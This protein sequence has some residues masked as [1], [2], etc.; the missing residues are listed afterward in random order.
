MPPFCV[1]CQRFM[2]CKK[3]G[4]FVLGGYKTYKAADRYACE[5]CESSVISGFSLEGLPFS[6]EQI[7]ASKKM[8][9]EFYAE[10]ECV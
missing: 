8:G 7:E 2:R 9:A 1:P 10:K 4:V 5:D 6:Q 3:N